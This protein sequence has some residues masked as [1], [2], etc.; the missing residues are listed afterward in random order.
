MRRERQVEGG[1]GRQEGKAT[2]KL[3]TISGGRNSVLESKNLKV[4]GRKQYSKYY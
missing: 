1:E 3:A 4:M 2:L